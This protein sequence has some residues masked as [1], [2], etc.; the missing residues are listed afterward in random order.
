MKGG[1]E[2][3]GIVLVLTKNDDLIVGTRQA[4]PKKCRDPGIF[5]ALCTIGDC[6]FA[7]AMLDLG[8]SVRIMKIC[9]SAFQP[10]PLITSQ[11][12]KTVIN[13]NLS[14]TEEL[15]NCFGSGSRSSVRETPRDIARIVHPK[16]VEKEK[17]E[18][19]MQDETNEGKAAKSYKLQQK[20]NTRV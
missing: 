20:Y 11:S 5:S 14:G 10:T 4:L 16:G 2:L 19:Q 1:V 13:L 17:K 8:A 3:R 6:T 12:R 15:W 9:N 18:E 7:D